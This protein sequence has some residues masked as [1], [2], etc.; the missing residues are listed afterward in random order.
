M[1]QQAMIWIL[2]ALK[3]MENNRRKKMGMGGG[4]A[5]GCFV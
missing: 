3:A 5:A 2:F 1:Y 4:G